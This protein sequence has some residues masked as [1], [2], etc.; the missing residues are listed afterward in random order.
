[1][2]SLLRQ[3]GIGAHK[4]LEIYLA[5]NGFKVTRTM[6]DDAE[7]ALI[8]PVLSESNAEIFLSKEKFL[9]GSDAG[10]GGYG[11]TFGAVV[12]TDH[13]QG[14]FCVYI[15]QDLMDLA[16]ARHTDETG[17]DNR[18]GEMLGIPVCCRSH[19][20]S[21][22]GKFGSEQNDPTR[23]IKRK[24]DVIP[25][26]SHFPMYFGYG[27][28][29]HFPCSVNCAATKKIAIRNEALIRNTS[30]ELADTFVRYQFQNYLYSE[31]DGIFAFGDIQESPRSS[32]PT[33]VYDNKRLEA[34]SSALLSDIIFSCDS[35]SL[36]A[37]EIVFS[38]DGV[39]RLMADASKFRVA[40][41]NESRP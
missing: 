7:L 2:L 30:P 37:G 12:S 20:S 24:G 41:H 1:M 6:M 34:T 13:P 29:S 28:F 9:L 14:Y 27:L 36:A 35:I 17:N 31:Y 19:F 38:R 15:G 18:F 25:W 21:N 33:W 5:V 40:F 39:V 8:L 32:D 3:L 22:K 4:A 10:K 11:N 23:Y 26:C 16:E